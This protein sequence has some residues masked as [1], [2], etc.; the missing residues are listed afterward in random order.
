MKEIYIL[1]DSFLFWSLGNHQ[2]SLQFNE[3]KSSEKLDI[4][5]ISIAFQM[6]VGF[7]VDINRH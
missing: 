3:K 2:I 7:E 5:L 4:Y 1:V 6:K